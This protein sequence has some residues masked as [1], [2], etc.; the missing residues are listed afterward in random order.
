MVDVSEYIAAQL[1]GFD[2]ASDEEAWSI[3]DHASSL[4]WETAAV[5]RVTLPDAAVKATT[6]VAQAAQADSR[7]HRPILG[8]FALL[9]V[10]LLAYGYLT[11]QSAIGAA[12]SVLS[13]AVS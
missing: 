3:A 6:P 11:D 2:A 4:P 10:P 12:V 7:F 1:C 5:A 13:A 8:K 9:G